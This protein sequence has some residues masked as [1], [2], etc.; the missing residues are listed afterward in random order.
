MKVF[1]ALVAILVIMEHVSARHNGKY[2]KNSNN[3]A[4][5]G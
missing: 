1:V 3:N 4:V 5:I 2:D